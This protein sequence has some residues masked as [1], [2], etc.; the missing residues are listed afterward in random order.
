MYTNSHSS[1]CFLPQIQPSRCPQI[2]GNREGGRLVLASSA[3]YL[4]N[5]S[6]TPQPP[7]NASFPVCSITFSWQISI[8][9]HRLCPPCCTSKN[10]KP[11]PAVC[12]CSCATNTV[13]P[14][15]VTA[16]S[17]PPH[18][19][20]PIRLPVK[21]YQP[22]LNI[23]KVEILLIPITYCTESISNFLFHLV[24]A[25]KAEITH[26]TVCNSQQFCYCTYWLAFLWEFSM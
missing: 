13:P 11:L 5:W 19:L 23:F 8:S 6:L 21:L 16:I 20:R 2:C 22:S 17:S 14:P 10:R 18:L 1:Y 12:R 9:S 25:N 15:S 24:K 4:Q 7:T 3:A 26:S